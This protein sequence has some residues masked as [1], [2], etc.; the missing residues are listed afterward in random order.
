MLN[1]PYKCG[2]DGPGTASKRIKELV[3]HLNQ[4][5]IITRQALLGV[6][7]VSKPKKLTK[8]EI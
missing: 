3:N 7:A 4:I 6:I 1:L 2:F 8:L 5:F